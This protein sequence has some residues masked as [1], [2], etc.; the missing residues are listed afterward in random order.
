MVSSHGATSPQGHHG[1]LWLRNQS[2]PACPWCRWDGKQDC[3]PW[4]PWAKPEG[5]RLV[6]GPHF[7]HLGPMMDLE[8]D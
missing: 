1:W 8:K 5:R 6:V 7:Q 4:L 3:A 2:L